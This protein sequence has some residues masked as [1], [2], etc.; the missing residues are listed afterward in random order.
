MNIIHTITYNKNMQKHAKT[1]YSLYSSLIVYLSGQLLP[2]L[3]S[4]RRRNSPSLAF[5]MGGE[6]QG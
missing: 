3:G 4:R 2:N 1:M 6:R 5:A